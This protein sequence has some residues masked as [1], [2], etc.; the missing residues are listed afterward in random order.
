VTARQLLDHA[1]PVFGG[2]VLPNQVPDAFK[3]L[4]MR[5]EDDDPILG[6]SEKIATA[7][8]ADFSTT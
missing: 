2:C 5:F 4:L 7:R 6:T 8:Q 3:S 1:H